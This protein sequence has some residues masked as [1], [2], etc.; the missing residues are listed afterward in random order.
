MNG[1]KTGHIHKIN[2]ETS[3]PLQRLRD[4]LRKCGERGATTAEIAEATGLMSISTWLSHLGHIG[5][6]YEKRYEGQ[7]TN[8]NRVYRYWLREEMR[9]DESGQGMLV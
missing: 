5:I 3:A 1:V 7:T 9:F 4:F 6:P 8:G 2:I